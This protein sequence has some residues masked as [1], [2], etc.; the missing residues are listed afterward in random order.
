MLPAGSARGAAKYG[1]GVGGLGEESAGAGRELFQPRPG[2]GVHAGQ[3]ALEQRPGFEAPLGARRGGGEVGDGEVGEVVVQGRAVGGEELAELR[4]GGHVVA[5][6]QRV[7]AC[8]VA[9]PG[10]EPAVFG[11]VD[12][13]EDA[14]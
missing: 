11:R 4:V 12:R 5:L 10:G 3:R 14:G 8:G 6:G 1:S 2:R 7:E 9:G 13:G